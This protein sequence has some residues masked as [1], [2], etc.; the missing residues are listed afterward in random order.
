MAYAR[1]YMLFYCMPVG[2]NS[3][4][5]SGIYDVVLRRPAIECVAVWNA[6]AS[7][8]K[9]I[10]LKNQFIIGV[11]LFTSVN[12]FMIIMNRFNNLLSGL[13]NR[14]E[15]VSVKNEPRFMFFLPGSPKNSNISF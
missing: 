11:K 12:R 6:T 2:Y 9:T 10:F 5:P 7:Q 14:L 4:T 13:V 3:W 1:G 15:P 8:V